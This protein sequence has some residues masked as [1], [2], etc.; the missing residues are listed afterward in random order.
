M[1]LAKFRARRYRSLH[2]VAVEFGGLKVFIG[3]NA[4]G[5]STILDA[6]RFL[7]EGTADRDFAGAVRERGGI[8][9]LV[10]KGTAAD[11]VELA[12]HL[13]D[14]DDRFH[15][16]L[17][18]VRDGYEFYL[19]EQMDQS[20]IGLP[21]TQ[22]LH[23]RRGEGSWWS[24][25]GQVRLE[26][27]P[28]MCALVAAAADASFRR[29]KSPSMCDGGVS[30]TQPPFCFIAT[31]AGWSSASSTRMAGIWPRRSMPHTDPIQRPS[32]AFY[33]QLETC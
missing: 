28:T 9:N 7:H 32:S 1:R 33:A 29:G 17:R 16:R 14:G 24:D 18:F 31:G 20:V 21:P 6:L 12:V 2:D 15:W 23:A 5:K 3:A 26:Q 19:E 4:V 30:S 27:A 8:P 10:W 13:E 25:K 22:I 11:E